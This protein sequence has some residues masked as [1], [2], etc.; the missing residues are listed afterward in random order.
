MIILPGGKECHGDS[1]GKIIHIGDKLRFRG[2]EY[3]LKAFGPIE[4]DYGVATLIFEEP[5][6]TEEIPHECNVDKV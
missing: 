3:T 1:T 6:H 4:D 5:V 2:Q